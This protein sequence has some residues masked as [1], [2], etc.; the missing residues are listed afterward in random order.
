MAYQTNLLIMNA[1]K[2]RFADFV[3][4]GLPLVLLMLATLSILLV[5]RYGL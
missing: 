1:A 3:R 5:Q 2:Y 4:V